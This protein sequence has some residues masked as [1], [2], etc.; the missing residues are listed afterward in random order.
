MAQHEEPVSPVEAVEQAVSD[1]T[2]TRAGEVLYSSKGKTDF[3]WGLFHG[4]GPERTD[5]SALGPE[6]AQKVVARERELGKYAYY[7][8]RNTTKATAIVAAS[9]GAVLAFAFF[10]FVLVTDQSGLPGAPLRL[11]LAGLITLALV[12][13]CGI[14]VARRARAERDPLTLSREEFAAVKRARSRIKPDRQIAEFDD[15]WDESSAIIVTAVRILDEIEASPAWGSKHLDADRIQLDRNEEIYQVVDSCNQ[16][17]KLSAAVER[18]APDERD[19]SALA[20]KLVAQADEYRLLR[21]EARSAI[22]ARVAAL[23]EYRSRLAKVEGLIANIDRA[24]E[25]V[26]GNDDFAEAFTAITRD[27]AA[28]ARTRELSAGLDDLR[29]RLTVEL[30]F[31]H[32]QVIASADLGT[33]LVLRAGPNQ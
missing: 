28:A 22:V 7:E 26:A 8:R 24:M 27:R 12:G 17:N 4:F 21:D 15:T 18:T 14:R 2:G 20:G 32:N 16:L 30:D 23:Y 10:V 3:V 31:I 29:E 11:A 33:P 13:L 9:V 6:L 19:D 25:V 5:L 1:L